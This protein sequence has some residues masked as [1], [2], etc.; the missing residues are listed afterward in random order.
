MTVLT[1]FQPSTD[2]TGNQFLSALVAMIPILAMLITLGGLRWRAHYAGLFSWALACIVAVAVF[3]MPVAMVAATS[4]EGFLYGIFPIVWILLAAIW[5]YQVTVISGRFDDLRRTFYLISDDTRV[6]GLLIAFCFGGLLEALAG[7][8]APVAITTVMLIAIGFS[9]LRAA[10]VALLANTVP[11][12]FGA[13]GL[14]VLMAAKTADMDVYQIA[15]ITGR[16]TAILC[17]VVPFLLLAVMD[18]KHG[19]KQCWPFGLVVG[20]TFGITK[21]IISGSALYNLT[22]V[23]SAVVSV[24]VA[25]AFTRVWKPV[26]SAEARPRVG[27]PLVPEVEG[28]PV[29]AQSTDAS[30]LT[31]QRIFMAVVPYVLV[32]VVFAIANLAPVAKFAKSLDVKIPWPVLSGQ[33][34]DSVGKASSHQTYTF[35]WASTPGI[36]LAFVAILVG[37]IYKVSMKDLFGELVVNAKKM[38]FTVLTIGSVVALAYVMGDSGQTLALGMWIAGAGAVYPFLAPILGWIGTYVTGSDTSA[39]ILFSGLQAGVGDQIGHKALLVGSNAAGGVVGKMISPQSLA[40][41]AT[42]M[43]LAGSESTVLRKVIGWSLGLLV[44]LCLVSGLM[45]TPVLAWVLP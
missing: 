42:A 45:S 19:V 12:A 18:G 22:E 4:A 2:P 24:V 6:L 33:L 15:P 40:I 39:N 43:S 5:M 28:E 34:L 10:I 3:K 27:A 44:V 37:L 36:L 13:V 26:G 17:I 21:W 8:G 31:R 32:I 23:F 11:V 1:G 41:A 14:P 29:E 9:K 30:D 38:K 16:I 25:I 7:F 20:L 35:S